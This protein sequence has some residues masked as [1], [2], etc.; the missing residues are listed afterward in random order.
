LLESIAI[1]R[2]NPVVRGLS[3][4][5]AAWAKERGAAKNIAA[6]AILKH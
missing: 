2:D 3:A 1:I 6:K 4:Q 5:S